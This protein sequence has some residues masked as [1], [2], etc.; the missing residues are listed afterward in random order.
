MEFYSNLEYLARGAF[1]KGSTLVSEKFAQGFCRMLER[2]NVI[3]KVDDILQFREN[4]P[5]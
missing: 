5:K 1:T 4:A 3:E 2:H